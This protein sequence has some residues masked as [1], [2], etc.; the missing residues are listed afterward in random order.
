MD[1]YLK[2]ITIYC[3]TA[4]G[5]KRYNLKASYRNT[6][7]LNKDNYQFNSGDSVIIRIFDKSYKDKINIG[8]IVVNKSVN[9]TITEAPQTELRNKYGQN[10]VF[11][12]NSKDVFLFDDKIG[13]I[14]HIRLGCV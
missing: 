1:L 12:V 7:T 2:P 13:D 6:T 5:Y 3:K 8:D 10:N 14:E 4:N 11:K 9:D